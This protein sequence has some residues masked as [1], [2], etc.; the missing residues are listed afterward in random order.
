MVGECSHLQDTAFPSLRSLELIGDTDLEG[1]TDPEV[2]I[3]YLDIFREKCSK[4]GIK[5]ILRMNIEVE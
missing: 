5:F 2:G 4:A 3:G 1:T